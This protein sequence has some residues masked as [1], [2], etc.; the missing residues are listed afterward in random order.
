M[1]SFIMQQSCMNVW[2]IYIMYFIIKR[3]HYLLYI[4]SKKLAFKC[5]FIVRA[6][7]CHVNGAS[8]PIKG[9]I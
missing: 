9:T 8:L 1:N 6:F 5:I 7:L 2:E 4:G 3:I